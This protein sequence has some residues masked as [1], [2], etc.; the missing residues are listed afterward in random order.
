MLLKE[1]HRHVYISRKFGLKHGF[2]PKDT[3]PGHYGYTGLV[4][5]G[6]WPITLIP[7]EDTTPSPGL[8]TLIR[9]QSTNKPVDP[10]SGGSTLVPGSNGGSS[11]LHGSAAR[12]KLVSNSP[13]SATHPA[14]PHTVT[15]TVYLSEEPHFDVVLGR[16]FFERRQI[17]TNNAHPTDVY[18]LDTG[19]KIKCEL[20]ILK[21][22]KGEIVTV[23]WLQCMITG[24]AGI[25]MVVLDYAA[26][27][28]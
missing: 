24:W 19:E 23:T 10:L 11:T 2:I 7:D 14:S 16:S 17:R 6:S 3:L 4:N 5:L 8:S 25:I 13:S 26:W 27:T 15:M 22:G 9:P 28:C 12:S 20:V 21:D 18:C 1:G